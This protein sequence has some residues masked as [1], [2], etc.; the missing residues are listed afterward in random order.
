MAN[1]K[2]SAFTQKVVQTN[3]D[4]LVGYT[5]ADNVRITPAA[6]GDGIYLPLGGG[7][8][9][10]NLKL[11]DG[12]V[13]QIGS[14]ADLQLFHELS[15]SYISNNIGDLTI[16]NL[17]NDKD[18]IFQ[19]D[20]GAGGVQTYFYLD[21]S[22][23]NTRF[24]NPA[25]FSD[26][27]KAKFGDGEDLEIYHDT[28]NSFI[29]NDTG[30]LY[31]RNNEDNNDI[32][33]QSDNG[34]GST[35]TYFFLDGSETETGF[36]KRTHHMDNVEARFGDGNDL[37]IYHD[38]SHSW[39]SDQGAG[40]L[41]ILTS[42]LNINSADDTKVMAT[43]IP[44]GAVTLKY[45]NS[46]K[47]ATTS[48]GIE[49]TDEVSIGTS[50]V[51]TGDTDTKVSFGTDEIVLTTA[52]TDRVTVKPDGKVGIGT[53]S[54]PTIFANS[55]V[56]NAAASGLGTS[57]D[58]LNWEIPAGATSQGYVAS[59][60]NTQTAAGN[61]NAGIL[62]EIGSTD[63]TTR[64]LSLESGG[65]NRFEVKGDGNV[66]IGTAAP[67][68]ALQVVG[69]VEYADNAAALAAGLTAGAFYRTGDLLKVVH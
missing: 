29:I 46:T 69:L 13:L 43:F 2:F 16:R 57:V 38:G 53:A 66:G 21:G 33:F 37:K 67:T 61:F 48:T 45:D 20:D 10:G 32:C 56:A 3:V 30:V 34:T 35:A 64:L 19:S 63:V 4:F 28:S 41:N 58:G 62:V 40:N 47:F 6:L 8:M 27:V 65:T 36:L 22:A 60:A 39:I 5:G 49:V 24:T 44:S 12:V 52:G 17:G 59:F 1:I 42:S 55:A 18:I 68:A 7:T 50:L 26:N 15:N 11:N 31:I 51:H 25:K 9:T 14:S 54:P 23:S